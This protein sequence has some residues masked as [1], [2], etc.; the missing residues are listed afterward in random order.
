M[1]M[2]LQITQKG[3]LYRAEC[4]KCG[5]SLYVHEWATWDN[6][7]DRDALRDGTYQCDQCSGRADPETFQY[8]GRQ[9]A[10]RYTMPGYLDCTDWNYGP[11]KRRLI[12]ETRDLYGEG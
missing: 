8:C 1:T 7:N 3:A 11:N 10:A 5:A 6:N 2:Q 12:R 4:A 9:Y